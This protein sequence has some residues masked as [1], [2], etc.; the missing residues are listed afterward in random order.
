LYLAQYWTQVQAWYRLFEV[1]TKVLAT[2]SINLLLSN[3]PNTET[4]NTTT[5]RR[6]SQFSA[7][8]YELMPETS[9]KQKPNP[10]PL[11]SGDSDSD[12]ESATASPAPELTGQGENSSPQMTGL[13]EITHTHQSTN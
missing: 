8:E 13:G 9:P 6:P 11:T 7:L 1:I 10:E 12:F 2:Q 3:W 5:S 4:K